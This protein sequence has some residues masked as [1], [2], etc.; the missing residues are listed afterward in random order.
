MN[1]S[2]NLE[3]P[4]RTPEE[5][6]AKFR[7]LITVAPT[8]VERFQLMFNPKTNEQETKTEGALPGR[9]GRP[10]TSP[11]EREGHPEHPGSAGQ[12]ETCNPGPPEG[13]S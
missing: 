6:A 7:E 4:G 1:Y 8:A 13:F 10:A 5:M 9:A 3:G 2:D 12:L 11:Q